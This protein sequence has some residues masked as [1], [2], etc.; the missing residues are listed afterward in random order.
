MKRVAVV[1]QVFNESLFLPIWISHYGR[2][3]GKENLFI[4]D[5]SSSDGSTSQNDVAKSVL[6]KKKKGQ[7]DEDDRSLLMSLFSDHL[8]KY[9]DIVIY[10]DCDEIIVLDPLVKNN[11]KDYLCESEHDHLGAI[12][13]DVLHAVLREDKIDCSR[14]LFEQRH[15]VLFNH[16]Y[17]KPLI[18]KRSVRF[19]AG[20]HSSD[21]KAYLDKNLI[22]FHLRS[23]DID[24][25]KRRIKNL[26]SIKFSVNS[27]D[28]NHSSHFRMDEENYL[29]ECRY[30]LPDEIFDNLDNDFD[31]FVSQADFQ[32]RDN[33]LFKIP[34]RFKNSVELSRAILNK[35]LDTENGLINVISQNEKQNQ[36]QD[37]FDLC[38]DLMIASRLRT[39]SESVSSGSGKLFLNCRGLRRFPILA[40]LAD[41]TKRFTNRKFY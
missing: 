17:C 33:Q 19:A 13:F 37:I 16:H 29:V 39:E 36:F 10:T 21:K 2:Q 15:F 11:L 35:D 7:L 28:K 1:T 9:Y 14:A 27:L 31:E 20:F 8:L 25:S 40:K 23:V 3:F 12:G 26:N 32:E 18:N 30:R 22:L 38:A 5:D 4:V 41:L 24:N 34:T 6:I